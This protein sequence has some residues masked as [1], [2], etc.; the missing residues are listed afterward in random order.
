MVLYIPFTD[1]KTLILHRL[2]LLHYE[3]LIPQTLLPE[4][5]NGGK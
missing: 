4:V 5:Y 3:P 1:V 2:F